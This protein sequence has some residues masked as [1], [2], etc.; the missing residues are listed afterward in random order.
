M[1]CRYIHDHDLLLVIVRVSPSLVSTG[2]FLITCAEIHKFM[3]ECT[4]TY[5][6]WYVDIYMTTIFFWLLFGVC[7]PWCRLAAF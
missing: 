1:V 2:C 5:V 7:L 4:Y 6:I 3:H